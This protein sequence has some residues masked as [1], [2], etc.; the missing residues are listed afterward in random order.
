M[1]K[2]TETMIPETGAEVDAAIKPEAAPMA[3]VPPASEIPPDGTA[4][5]D[6]KDAALTVESQDDAD[7]GVDGETGVSSFEDG[8]KAERARIV[9]LDGILAA[10]PGCGDIVGK[11]K[12]EGWSYEQASKAVFDHMTKNPQ[13]T[14]GYLNARKNEY[15]NSGAAGVKGAAASGEEPPDQVVNSILVGMKKGR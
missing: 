4:G 14:G 15:E 2:K 7:G 10:C 3:Q 8:V 9:A 1:A 12:A 11:A 6:V 13:G 5:G